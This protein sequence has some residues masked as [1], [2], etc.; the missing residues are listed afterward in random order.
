[1]LAADDFLFYFSPTLFISR[2][3]ERS[4]SMM[5]DDVAS[6]SAA[7]LAVR[8]EHDRDSKSSSALPHMLRR[9]STYSEGKSKVSK[10]T[11]VKAAFKWERANVPALAEGVGN[12]SVVV[13]NVVPNKDHTAASVGLTPVNNEVARWLYSHQWRLKEYLL[14][15][16]VNK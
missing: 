16:D 14:M 10:W 4:K 8:V 12:S 3:R 1:M 11:K 9:Q 15:L 7:T 5:I 13:Y 2:Q 6:T